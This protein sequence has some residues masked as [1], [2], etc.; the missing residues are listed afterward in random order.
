M[1]LWF[2]YTGSFNFSETLISVWHSSKVLLVK[3]FHREP[4]DDQKNV[5]PPSSLTGWFL[6]FKAFLHQNAGIIKDQKKGGGGRETVPHQ[7][8]LK[9]RA[10]MLGFIIRNI[11]LVF[12]PF[13]SKVLLKP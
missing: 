5:F 13:P 12:V 1:D 6:K 10:V 7:R 3:V 8:R 11:Y 2:G 4:K 9:S